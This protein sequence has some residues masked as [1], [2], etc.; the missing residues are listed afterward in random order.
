MMH[1]V[2]HYIRG[3]QTVGR[4]PSGGAV[5]PL[6]GGRL[7][8]CMRDIIILNEI[9]VQG[10]IYIFLVG[11]FLGR[12]ILLTTQYRYWLRSVSSTV[13]RRLNLEQ[14]TSKGY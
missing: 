1:S 13:C 11:T 14:C 2:A 10:R 7:V 3:S 6:W 9:W 4:A 5:G 12:N 8:D